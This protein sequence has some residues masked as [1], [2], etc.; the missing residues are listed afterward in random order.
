MA[1]FTQST[2]GNVTT[3][4]VPA[5]GLMS[6]VTELNKD[7][8]INKLDMNGEAA[9]P[10]GKAAMPAGKAVILAIVAASPLSSPAPVNCEASMPAVIVASPLS[11]PA[12]VNGEA[13]M[14]AVVAASPL[15]GPA[16]VN[17]KAAMPTVVGVTAVAMPLNGEA[18]TSKIT[19]FEHTL[20]QLLNQR[21]SSPQKSQKRKT[22]TNCEVITTSK[23]LKQKEVSEELAKQKEILRKDKTTK[24]NDC[25]EEVIPNKKWRC[26]ETKEDSK[27]MG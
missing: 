7:D 24:T 19:S 9:M 22:I 12:P 5:A 27:V 2:P 10:A 8:S 20:L 23:Y 1:H 18:S 6:E 16:P 13:A 15:S 14:P 26:K 21:K 4:S 25:H 17:G 3:M 11:I